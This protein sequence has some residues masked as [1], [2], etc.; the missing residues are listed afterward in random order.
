ML[1][2]PELKQGEIYIGAIINADGSGY[3]IVLL[4]GDEKDTWQAGMD[5]A[6]EQGGDLPSRV[7]QAILFDKFKS[8]FQEDWYWSNTQH[9]A[10]AYYA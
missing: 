8:E 4:A 1:A 9:S 3:H 7:E 10:Y 2:K 5:L 6:K